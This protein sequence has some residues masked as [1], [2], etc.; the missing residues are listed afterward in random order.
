[1]SSTISVHRAIESQKQAQDERQHMQ[2]WIENL[3][4]QLR[5][6]NSALDRATI[7]TS[8]L[9]TENQKTID[10]LVTDKANAVA[11]LAQ[12]KGQLIQDNL[13][14]EEEMEE[15]NR[16]LGHLTQQIYELQEL[17]IRA[18]KLTSEQQTE[19]ISLRSRQESGRNPSLQFLNTLRPSKGQK[20]TKQTKPIVAS[21]PRVQPLIQE[22]DQ[23]DE[24]EQ[25][26]LSTIDEDIQMVDE[27]ETEPLAVNRLQLRKLIVEILRSLPEFK[28]Q[29]S[30]A[31][32]QLNSEKTQ[33]KPG[34][35][36]SNRD[37]VKKA[38]Q[39]LS[40]QEEYM[41]RLVVRGIFKE[42]LQVPNVTEFH[43]YSSATENEVETY[44]EEGT[45]GP[46]ESYQLYFGEIPRWRKC[47]WNQKV[48]ANITSAIL[49]A[50][51]PLQ[52]GLPVLDESAI[53][54]FVWTLIEQGRESW[55]S[56]RRKV[57]PTGELETAVEAEKRLSDRKMKRQQDSLM[58]TR[59]LH[60]SFKVVVTSCVDH[61]IGTGQK[62]DHRRVAI[63]DTLKN[64][65][66]DSNKANRWK[67]LQYLVNT[68]GKDGQSSD[69]DFNTYDRG[70]YDQALQS[71]LPHWRNKK[72]RELLSEVDRASDGLR[73]LKKYRA[74]RKTR[75][76]GETISTRSRAKTGL[77]MSFYD[78]KF[79]QSLRPGQLDDLQVVETDDD[80]NL[81]DDLSSEEN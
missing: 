38:F 36:S 1:M 9:Q 5:D 65:N 25:V 76:P 3:E 20:T 75:V 73:L 31:K 77:P 78:R 19:L 13:E 72:I 69:E 21:G 70:G 81:L 7:E 58:R 44:E 47:K 45:G 12:L 57:K 11:E 40:A 74:A 37:I 10:C 68:L 55:S 49:S 71:T 80:F 61:L 22:Q 24:T 34:S 14:M 46:G 29:S 18:E 35:R 50:H 33:S 43:D 48:V 23:D 27:T 79:L 2:L 6:V 28:V 32:T 15:K 63:E 60:V 67:Q 54:A 52:T 8:R 51:D 4:S 17:H 30:S 56:S 53:K 41:W 42:L 62:Y 66:P 59:K 39:S 64:L 16:Q 26:T